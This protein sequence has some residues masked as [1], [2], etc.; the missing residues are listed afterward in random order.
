MSPRPTKTRRVDF[1]PSATYFKPAGIPLRSLEEVIITFEEM[2]ALRLKDF[3]GIEQ[4]EASNKMKISQ[5]TFFRVLKSARKKV[6]EALTEGKAIKIEGG[7]Y[8]LVKK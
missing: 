1:N 7:N 8:S 2:E 6:S 3:E 5:P 4:I